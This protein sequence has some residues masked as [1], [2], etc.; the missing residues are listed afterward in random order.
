MIVIGRSGSFRTVLRCSGSLRARCSVIWMVCWPD[1]KSACA[2][3]PLHRFAVPLPHR[4]RINELYSLNT[5][6]VPV[7]GKQLWSTGFVGSLKK[8]RA[9]RAAQGLPPVTPWVAL[10]TIITW[11]FV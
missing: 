2:A 1:L 3:G 6:G 8:S 4:G 5:S 7:A 9:A 11:L 10:V